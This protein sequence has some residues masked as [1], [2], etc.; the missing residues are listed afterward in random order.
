MRR[1]SIGTQLGV[2]S[3]AL[4]IL[5][6][7]I[8][9]VNGVMVFRLVDQRAET[10]TRQLAGTGALVVDRFV[11]DAGRDLA[12]FASGDLLPGGSGE[13]CAES[14][15][16]QAALSSQFSAL[17]AVSSD[18]S[19]R[20]A[21]ESEGS[22]GGFRDTAELLRA[23]RSGRD[24]VV[25]TLHRR[26]GGTGW[27]IPVSHALREDDGTF[28]GAVVGLVDVERLHEILGQIPL[29]PDGI[30][31]IVEI[32]TGTILAR[33]S[34]PESWVGRVLD[35]DVTAEQARRGYAV[36]LESV[37]GVERMWGIEPA[38]R[39]D[40]T[41]NAGYPTEWIREPVWDTVGASALLTITLLLLAVVLSERVRRWIVGPIRD[42]VD[43]S[44]IAAGGRTGSI[45][46]RGPKELRELAGAFNRTLE[47]RT[48][49]DERLRQAEKRET[50]SRMAGGVA[51]EFRNLLTVITGETS[52]I[53]A[54][55]DDPETE[56]SLDLIA[57]A[58]K[59]ASALTDKLLAASEQDPTSMEPVALGNAV[60][61]AVRLLTLGLGPQHRLEVELAD[62]L[63]PVRCGRQRAE[64]ILR[65]LVSNA[66][67]A[68]PDGGTVRVRT[69]RPDDLGPPTGDGPERP[70]LENLPRY[71]AVLEVEDEG[72]GIG[73]D[74]R[75]RIFEPF[76]TARAG[77]NRTGLG[78]STV[79][80]LVR[81][82]GGRIQI[83]S[84]PGEG[85][86]VRVFFAFAH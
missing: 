70:G 6:A 58:T 66:L 68:M 26:E 22:A 81:Q 17:L 77:A 69:L 71:A 56:D 23:L 52:L 54:D 3:G 33:T 79:R 15:R 24:L 44:R 29:P 61:E 47:D 8:V 60:S 50:V 5:A 62:D 36:R 19:I 4:V 76:F 55:V 40:W 82:A 75:D 53:R 1:S 86:R 10:T 78:L 37:D 35:S 34:E 67:D 9:V 7:L 16:S 57:E 49:L 14:L 74:I 85:T 83:R 48:A 2:L 28:R 30:L 31:T 45:D 64:V 51:H 39:V 12:A 32:S 73:A 11:E 27:I 38:T 42:L 20:C 18:G 21:S 63:P 43:Q 46:I 41:V 25:G 13:G 84:E 59:R 72:E 65:E 80:G